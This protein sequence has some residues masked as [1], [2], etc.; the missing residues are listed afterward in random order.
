M[1]KLH[2]NFVNIRRGYLKDDGFTLLEMLVAI[3]IFLILV[4]ISVSLLDSGDSTLGLERVKSEVEQAIE[5]AKFNAF[6]GKK[7]NDK[8]SPGFGVYFDTSTLNDKNKAIIVFADC[9]AGEDYDISSVSTDETVCD[10]EFI[11][12]YALYGDFYV[13]G[14]CLVGDGNKDDLCSSRGSKNYSE[15]SM[16]FWSPFAII[17]SPSLDPSGTNNRYF[18]IEIGSKSNSSLTGSYI[19]VNKYGRSTISIK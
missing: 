17:G 14:L 6:N 1:G 15:H 19:L 18:K 13:M 10:D 3:A 2:I 9:D 8:H 11:E 12:E 5:V 7:H 16:I 4:T